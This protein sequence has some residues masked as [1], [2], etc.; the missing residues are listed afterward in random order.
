MAT[1]FNTPVKIDRLTTRGVAVCRITAA[2]LTDADTSQ[3]IT[4]SALNNGWGESAVPA[5]SR[6]MYAWINVIEGFEG[7]DATALTVTLGD[8]GAA[9][10]L[11]TAVS[12]FTGTEGLKVK[13]G[14]YT[15]GTFEA[16]YAP[17]ATFASTDGNLDDID[18]GVLE[19]CIA[20]ETISTESVTG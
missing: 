20:Y 18:T 8:A 9:T 12:V 2:D 10:E 7:G 14:T 11:I 6:I 13:S 17:I 19:V 4:L 3:A 15:L 16:A 5:N 1:E